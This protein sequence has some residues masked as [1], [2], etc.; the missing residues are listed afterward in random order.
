MDYYNGYGDK[1][2]EE[3]DRP[4]MVEILEFLPQYT[5]DVT[6]SYNRKVQASEV[7]F[8][9]SICKLRYEEKARQVV[10]SF[11]LEDTNE[12]YSSWN[13]RCGTRGSRFGGVHSIN[14]REIS[15][16]IC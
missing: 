4:Q 6:S 11:T 12:N 2:Q 8:T 7:D 1:I 9:D 5:E 16:I 14:I 10:R 13:R 3:I 15:S